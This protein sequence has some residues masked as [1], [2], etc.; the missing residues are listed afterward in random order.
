MT[1][2]K[3]IREEYVTGS[4]AMRPLAEKCGVSFNTLK[5]HAAREAWSE[6]RREYREIKAQLL[7]SGTT[8]ACASPPGTTPQNVVDCPGQDPL[9]GADMLAAC[10]MILRRVHTLLPGCISMY[11]IRSAASALQDIGA[12][13]TS[14]PSLEVEERKARI[15]RLHA[16]LREKEAAKKPGILEVRFLGDTEECSK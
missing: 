3:K 13:L 5:E 10:D 6:K 11:E 12:I 7:R 16:E 2:W 9:I 8:F 15:E 4:L 1:D 14:H